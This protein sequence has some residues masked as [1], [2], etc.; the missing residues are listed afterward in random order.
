MNDKMKDAKCVKKKVK[1]VP[2]D[3]L[4]ENYLAAFTPHKQLTLEQ[5]FWSKDLLKMKEE[6]LK[7][8]IALRPINALTVY[9]PNTPAT[10]IPGGKENRVNI[11]KSIDDGPFQMRTFWETLTE[12]NESA[13]HLGLPKDIYTLINHYTD[14]KNIW[15]NVKMLLEGLE[16]TKEN[17]EL[18]LYD[19]IEHFRQHKGGTI[20]DYFVRFVKLI[21]DMRNIKM[22]MSRMQLNSKFVNNMLPE[23]G[24]SITAV[25]LNRELRVSNYDQLY[26]YLKQHEAHANGNKM[27]LD[28]LTQHTVDPLALMSNVSHQMFKVNKIEVR[29]TMHGVQ[30]QLVME[31]LRT[32]LEMQIQENGVALDEEQLLFIVGRQDNAVDEDL[33]KQPVQDLALNIDNVF[34]VNDCDAFDFDVDEA[35]TAQTMFM[36]NLS[37]AYLV[38]DEAGPSYDSDILSEVHDH[39]H[40]QDTVCEHHE[41]HEMHDDVQ[42][43]YV[44]DSH[45]DYTSDSNMILYD[46]FFDMHEAFNAAQK[47]IAE[48]ESEKCSKQRQYDSR[49]EEKISQLTKKHSDADPIHNLKALDS[50]NKELHAKVNALYDLNK[51]WGAE[52][53]KVKRHNKELYDSIKVVQIVL[54]YLDSGCSKH[55]TRDRSR[56]RNF[57]KKFIRTVRFRNDYFGTI[58]GYED[59]VIGEIVIPRV[60]YVEGLGHNLFS[61]RQLCDYDLEVAFRKHSCYVRDTDGVELIKGSCGSNLYMISVEDIM[62]SSSIYLLSK[63][64]KNKSWLWHRCLN[65][66]N[67]GTINNLSRKDL[68]RGLPR[69]KFEKYHLC[70]ACQLGKN[71]KHTHKPKAENTNLEVLNTLHMDICGP[72]RE[73]T[74]NGKKYILVIVDDYSRV[75]WVKF[76][77]SKDENPEV[78]IKFLKQIQVGLNKTVS[79]IRTDNGTGFV[80]KDLTEYYERMHLLQVIHHPSSELQSPSLQQGVAAKSTI[81]EDNTL[82]PVDTDPFVNVFASKPSSEASSSGDVS[83]SESTY[84]TQTHHHLGKWCTNHRLIMSMAIPLDRYPPKNNWQPMPC[85][86]QD[87]IYEFDRLQVW[88]LV[89]Y[90]N[91]VMIIALKWIYKVKFDEYG[92]VMKNKAR[93]MAKGY[94]QE[95]GIDFE[96][97]FAPVA[98]IEAMRIFIANA[99]SKNMTIYQMNVKTTFLNGELKEKVYVSQLEGFIDPDHLTHVYRLKKV[100]YVLKQAPRAWYD[101]LS[102]FLLDNKFSKG[103]V[104]PTLFTWKTGKH[105]LLVQIYVDDIIFSSTDPKA[106]DICYLLI[107]E[108]PISKHQNR[109]PKH[110]N[111][112]NTKTNNHKDEYTNNN[113]RW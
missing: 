48:L 1:I 99:A 65:H 83:S 2:H 106:C 25:K 112:T 75:T 28:R 56:L 26:A 53:E 89:P 102:R 40:N 16:L 103:A 47:R 18:Q 11:L 46:Q 60:Y 63:A 49:V 69:L 70:S 4:K 45:T 33:D 95:E 57:V 101:I 19:D 107:L 88:E 84:V 38:Y 52:N 31:E 92:D 111:H 100:V 15:D 78:V 23:W 62:K 79:F 61:V 87:E 36:A 105:I 82:A 13:L 108:Y 98:R 10:L 21:N 85:A 44:V 97:S 74:I 68:V 14:A 94:R 7:E 39:D 17:R 41:V 54:S 43:Y 29:G 93:L 32:K 73:Q 67:F 72:I 37:F 81:M 96:E 12:G 110:A 76:L 109:V 91:C 42:P 8:Q 35:L 80:S 9:P 34:Q 5:I 51:R 86:L 66:L 27:M 55:M 22:T 104:D 24:R 50:Q 20:H 64:S 113:N 71:K 30:V 3:Y 90:P 6:A 77:R 59:Y 58:M